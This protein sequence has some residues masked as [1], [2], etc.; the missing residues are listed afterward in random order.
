LEQL[1]CCCAQPEGRQPQ[2]RPTGLCC[3]LPAWDVWPR[4]AL[5]ATAAEQSLGRS[6][7]L[8]CGVRHIYL[9]EDGV[10][11]IGEDDAWEEG[12]AASRHAAQLG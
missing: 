2:A 12:G 11:I 8:S 10:A 3:R 1:P 6:A 9:A 7:H 4:V 5:A